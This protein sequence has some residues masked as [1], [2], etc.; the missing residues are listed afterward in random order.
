MVQDNQLVGML[1]ESVFLDVAFTLIQD[2]LN[3]ADRDR[4]G[5]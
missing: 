3:E 4:G 5:E 2:E 1:T